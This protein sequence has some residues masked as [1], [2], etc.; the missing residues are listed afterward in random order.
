MRAL[1]G[2]PKQFAL[3]R[4]AIAALAFSFLSAP[5]HAN[6]DLS[7]LQL[8]SFLGGGQAGKALN[9]GM[10]AG[11]ALAKVLDNE[12]PIRLDAKSVFPTVPAPPGGP[13][14]VTS[15]LALTPESLSQPLP[16][17][18]YEIPVYAYAMDSSLPRPGGGV[19][20]QLGALRGRAAEA[21]STLFWRGQLANVNPT[22]IAVTALNI[23]SG[24]TYAHLPPG[25]QKTV[26]L[27][28]PDMKDQLTGDYIETLEQTYAKLGRFYPLPALP[29]LLAQMGPNGKTAL[30]AMS[31]QRKLQRQA[32]DDQRRDEVLVAGQESGVY[33][34]VQAEVGPWTERVPGI[35]YMR[36]KIVA[37]PMG[38]NT[39]QMRVLAASTASAAT[40]PTLMSL[41]GAK[42][43]PQAGTA[44]AGLV[45]YSMFQPA[46]P[47]SIYPLIAQR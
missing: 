17:G 32:L 44:V 30:V 9:P 16:A 8:P 4:V 20:Y 24:V 25:C 14:A 21:I 47:L 43:R 12:L 22:L 28:I 10:L 29:D 36:L 23:Q 33:A 6:I 37:G 26:E 3:H 27:L 2:F 11:T 15:R 13:F 18:D 5:A 34:P 31:Q 40:P 39:L 45:G 35:A 7:R 38:V 19:A 1:S 41:F 42:A 46:Q